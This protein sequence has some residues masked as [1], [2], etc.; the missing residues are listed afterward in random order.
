MKLLLQYYLEDVDFILYMKFFN[1]IILSSRSEKKIQ[2]KKYDFSHL[3]MHDVKKF[4]E[5]QL[6][7]PIPISSFL[8]LI[9]VQRFNK[10]NLFYIVFYSDSKLQPIL[11]LN[12]NILTKKS[13]YASS[14]KIYNKIDISYVSNKFFLFLSIKARRGAGAQSVTA[15]PT[16]CRFDPTRRDEI[17]ILN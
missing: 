9:N 4:Y 17:F 1:L 13:R 11:F 6:F 8:F 3:N 14:Y 5:Q 12:H 10:L 2:S 16:G 15:K 7:L